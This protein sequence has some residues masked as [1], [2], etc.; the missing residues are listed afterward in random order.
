MWLFT[1]AAISAIALFQPQKETAKPW[2]HGRVA[3]VIDAHTFG[4]QPDGKA[5][6]FT[7]HTENRQRL[8]VGQAAEVQ[9]IELGCDGAM[10]GR[11]R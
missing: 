11:V 9:P 4:F 6:W 10:R 5:F 3:E 2:M 8:Q 7:I 1:F